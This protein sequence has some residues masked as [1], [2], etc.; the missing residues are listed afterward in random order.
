MTQLSPNQQ[1]HWSRRRGTLCNQ[2]FRTW[3]NAQGKQGRS[4]YLEVFTTIFLLE[5]AESLLLQSSS[6]DISLFEDSTTKGTHILSFLALLIVH[7]GKLRMLSEALGT[8]KVQ[9]QRPLLLS[10]KLRLFLFFLYSPLFLYTLPFR[11]HLAR[12]ESRVVSWLTFL[13]LVFFV[14]LKSKRRSSAS[15][16]TR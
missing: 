16:A 15:I 10:R 4:V 5:K 3:T 2:T 6:K 7:N 14:S 13:V 12:L 8:Y 11:F 1:S 9:K